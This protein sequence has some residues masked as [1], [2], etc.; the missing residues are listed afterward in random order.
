MSRAEATPAELKHAAAAM[1]TLKT[2]LMRHAHAGANQ[3][4][5]QKADENAMA[6]LMILI[7]AAQR[8]ALQS[9]QHYQIFKS[10]CADM[11]ASEADAVVT[12]AWSEMGPEATNGA[13]VTEG[14]I[15]LPTG[16]DLAKLN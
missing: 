10:L 15:V 13:Q 12:R 8:Y 11:A 6:A 16:D 5:F 4:G 14:G 2:E 1:D 3:A 7:G 9:R